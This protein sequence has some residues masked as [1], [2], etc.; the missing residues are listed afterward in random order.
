[1]CSQVLLGVALCGDRRDRTRSPTQ[2]REFAVTLAIM[3]ADGMEHVL[4]LTDS[5]LGKAVILST[6]EMEAQLAASRLLDGPVE[7]FRARLADQAATQPLLVVAR[8][9]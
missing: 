9:P 4:E 8:T 1:M 2:L 7:A 6:L 5:G 3:V